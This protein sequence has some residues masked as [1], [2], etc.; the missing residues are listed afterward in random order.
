MFKKVAAIVSLSIIGI[1]IIATIVLACNTVKYGVPCSKPTSVY[2]QYKD[3]T[4]L[5]IENEDHLNKVY[6]LISSTSKEK[7]IS[8]LFNGNL[9]KKAE[10]VSATSTGK[11]LPAASSYFVRFVYS[12]AQELKYGNKQFKDKDGKTYTYEELVF[13]INDVDGETETIVYVIPKSSEPNVYSHYYLVD[14]DYSPVFTFLSQHNYN[15]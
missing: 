1:L 11:T 5:K 9:N 4:S 10:I 3:N 15:D 14:A 12:E 7:A 2:V 6:D 8:A 13:T